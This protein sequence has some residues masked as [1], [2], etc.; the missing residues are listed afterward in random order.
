[1]KRHGVN[2]SKNFSRAKTRRKS[3]ALG[4][5]FSDCYLTQREAESMALFMC[6]HTIAKAAKI[7]GLSPRSVEYYLEKIKTKTRCHSKAGLIE[8]MLSN[9]FATDAEKVIKGLGVKSTKMAAI[10]RSSS[11]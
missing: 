8:H 1:M 7:L 4:P 9:Q 10:N 6:G 3:Y 11:C 5:P 2:S